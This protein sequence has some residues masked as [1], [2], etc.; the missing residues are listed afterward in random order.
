MR[1]A[2]QKE[3]GYT[4][5][6]RLVPILFGTMF[7]LTMAGLF[8]ATKERASL[9]SL[10]VFFFFMAALTT[11]WPLWRVR[12][13]QGVRLARVRS[14]NSQFDGVLVPVSRARRIIILV[15]AIFLGASCLIMAVGEND[16]GPAKLWLGAIFFSGGEGLRKINAA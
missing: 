8:S 3:L 1:R 14:G 13:T 15:G 4:G 5:I 11:L 12:E 9:F 16:R 7:V 6:Y 2:T 10:A